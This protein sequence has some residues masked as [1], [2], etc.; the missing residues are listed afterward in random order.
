[1]DIQVALVSMTALITALGS[2]AKQVYDNRE[3]RKY[4][5]RRLPCEKRILED[6]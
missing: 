1:M 5:C 6:D 4:I 3:I 2:F